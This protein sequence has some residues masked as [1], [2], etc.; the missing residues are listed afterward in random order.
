M[1]LM[2]DIHI[3]KYYL[4]SLCCLLYNTW[5]HDMDIFT[6]FERY[7]ENG[8]LKYG[9]CAQLISASGSTS[10]RLAYA[11]N[12]QTELHNG[13]PMYLPQRGQGI[14]RNMPWTEKT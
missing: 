14:C 7:I 6:E 2:G 11:Q 5:D 13:R 4:L 1:I 12:G 8:Q 9:A 10:H 3:I